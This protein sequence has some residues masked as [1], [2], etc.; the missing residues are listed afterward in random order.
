[1]LLD[2]PIVDAGQ[3]MT[4]RLISDAD[5]S[6]VIAESSDGIEEIDDGYDEGVRRYERPY[7]APVSSGRYLAIWK[8]GMQEVPRTI[9]VEPSPDATLAS[10]DDVAAR[11]GRPLTDEE[12][13][14]QVPYL[15]HMAA[16][17]IADAAGY[18][19]GWVASLTPV[20]NLLRGMSVELVNRALKNPSQATQIR[21]QVGSYAY[22][23]AW[24]NPGFVLSDQEEAMIRRTV[25]G[26][27]TVSVHIASS[28]E[29]EQDEYWLRKQAGEVSDGGS[30]SVI[31]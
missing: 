15:L 31:D 27:T 7:T 2:V 24:A 22:Q 23:A 16:A 9:V 10:T 21:Q 29:R 12:L 8:Y 11:L 20:P 3:G 19:D 6:I 30:A 5:G 17:T 13:A 4:W 26:R 1:V 28:F 25:H 14:T 18:D